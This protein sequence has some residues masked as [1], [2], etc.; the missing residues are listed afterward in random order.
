MSDFTQ[1]GR[2]I[3]IETPLGKDELLLTAFE[4]VE[5][6]SSSFQFQLS[7]YS[8]N[9]EITP[10]SL[11]GK[12]ITVK[13]QNEQGRVFNGFVNQFSFGETKSGFREYYLTMVP[14]LWFLGKTESRRI[15][16]NKNCKD[17]VS[18]VFNQLGFSDFDFRAAG[19]KPREYC[20][21]YGES[22]L[23]FVLRLLEEEG[24]A[25]FFNHEAS[26]HTLVIVDKA[27]AYAECSETCLTYSKGSTPDSEIQKWR[28][29][30]EF[31]KG[32]WALN[33]YNFKEPSKSLLAETNS[34]SKFAN[35]DKF[36]HYSYSDLY[37][38]G[39]G[40]DLV[41]IR[42]DA[43][44]A[45]INTVEGQ[46]N[47]SSFYAGGFFKLDKHD[48]KSEKGSYLLLAVHHRATDSS[49][50]TG[51]SGKE[52]YVNTFK[53]MPLDVHFRPLQTHH[54]PVMKG[55]QSAIVTGPA[56]EEIFIDEFGRIKVQ[57]IWDREG[58]N[59]D[60]SSCFLRVMQSWAGKGWGASFIPRIGHEVIVTFLDGDPD[61]PI[62]SGTVYN[63][64]NKPPYSS[65][66]QSGIKTHS[67][68]GGSASNYNEL[69]F[70]DKKDAE[71]I[72]IHAEKDLD[73]MVENNET[74]T[75]DNDRTK[76]VKHDENSKID[77][78]RNKTVGKNQTENIGENKSIEVGKNHNEK[79]GK[80]A[81]IDVAENQSESVGKNIDITIA[82]N[83]TESVGKNMT[84]SVEK[85]L[86]ESVN[87]KYTETV[88]KEYGLQAK[89]ITMQ[90]EDQITLKTGS[91]QIVMKK[92]G[93][94]TI[95]GKNINVKG[96]GN[97]VLK[98]SKV[99]SN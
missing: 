40:S 22:D 91:A 76:H 21:Q 82:E 13:I 3:A 45:R 65:K 59:D 72:Y 9:L 5:T 1:D 37:D 38:F 92:N 49:Y 88:T 26:K 30:Y 89:T 29:V 2:F 62:V 79:I 86:K 43:E 70:E 47:C 4:G 58:K 74:L 80:N 35:N 25:C 39:S 19:G 46:S 60:N 31:R 33:D 7:A 78:N 94:I 53:C 50:H 10:E 27:N 95:S 63:G 93:D 66:T 67:T 55:P 24:Y 17:I 42:M 69:R 96:S 28:H 6:I 85:D 84:I 20:V 87:G 23:D 16:Q 32:G 71:Q 81:T 41:K 77:N 97:I 99:S 98:G 51:Q 54:R 18:Q 8:S 44:E 14:W 34:K 64:N 61:R 52:E 11:V 15:F 83:H 75:I 48:A 68:K 90:A 12:R 57:F 56:G 73:T 36:K